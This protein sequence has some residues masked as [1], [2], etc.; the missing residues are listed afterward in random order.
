MEEPIEQKKQKKPRSEAQVAAF[1]KG[2]AALQ[3]KREMLKKQKEEKIKQ[4]SIPITLPTPTPVEDVKP[5][6]P[7]QTNSQPPP[8]VA[9]NGEVAPIKERKP[10]QPRQVKDQSN[11]ISRSDF[12]DFKKDL[13]GLVGSRQR[14]NTA[15]QSTE[16]EKPF[17]TKQPTAPIK[18]RL[19]SGSELLDRIFFN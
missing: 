5:P 17:V 4:V 2:L 15:N 16:L 12:E 3:A 10:R 14:E 1:Q 13:Y 11:Q 9:H 7:T 8:P 6:I 18:E 19:I